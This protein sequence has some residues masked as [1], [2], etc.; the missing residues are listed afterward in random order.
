MAEQDLWPQAKGEVYNSTTSYSDMGPASLSNIQLR[1]SGS[2]FP[3]KN[4]Y[5]TLHTSAFADSPYQLIIFNEFYN[6]S[7]RRKP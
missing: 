6:I 2:Y 5:P 7:N 3:W 1:W 4:Q